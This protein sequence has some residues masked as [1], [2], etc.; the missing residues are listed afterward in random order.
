MQAAEKELGAGLVE[1]VERDLKRN[2][3]V[4]PRCPIIATEDNGA[5]LATCPDLPSAPTE[6]ATVSNDRQDASLRAIDR[7][8]PRFRAGSSVADLSRRSPGVAGTDSHGRMDQPN[9]T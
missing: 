1:N 4:L 2:E 8:R 9:E 7:S 6:A 5:I 3:Q